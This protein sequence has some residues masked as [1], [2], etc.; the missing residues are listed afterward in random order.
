[1][2]FGKLVGIINQ[3]SNG[4]LKYSKYIIKYSTY[5]QDLYSNIF[6]QSFMPVT[7]ETLER[8]FSTLKM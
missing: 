1:M 5:N 3:Y 7:T 8:T 6:F 4:L 2:D